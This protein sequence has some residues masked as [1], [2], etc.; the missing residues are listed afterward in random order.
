MEFYRIVI[1]HPGRADRVSDNVQPLLP[2]EGDRS[3]KDEE[4]PVFAVA[5]D[6]CT[7]GPTN[8]HSQMDGESKTDATG[9]NVSFV[10]L[11]INAKDHD[12]TPDWTEKFLIS[13]KADQLCPIASE[14]IDNQ[15]YQIE[16]DHTCF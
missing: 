16:D 8:H 15:R 7:A 2:S 11:T 4:Y 9:G 6:A 13:G 5:G 12:D 10:L 14:T 1:H 3:D